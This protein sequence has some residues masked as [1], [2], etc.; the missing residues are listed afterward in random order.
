MLRI[1][2]LAI[3]SIISSLFLVTFAA[4]QLLYPDVPWAE[5]T[6]YP[7]LIVLAQVL[8]YLLVLIFIYFTIRQQSGMSF[9][10]SVRWNWPLNWGA[11]LFAGVVLSLG[12]Q[13]LAHFLP[14]PKNLPIDRFFQTTREAYVLSIF[15][16]T[17]APLLE[18]LFF[19]G[20]LY[21]VLARRLGVIAAVVLA[22]LS[23]GLIHAPQLG[24]AWG[25][26]LVISLVGLVLTITRA[27]TKSVAAGLLIH[28]AYNGTISVLIF[29]A[30]DRFRHLEKLQQ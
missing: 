16:V 7:G 1:A 20:L 5:V 29:F 25:P 26:V 18:E 19:R 24:R 28:T 4:R 3:A 21:P 14:M 2:C 22:S 15:G 17:L 8:A 10:Q 30:S 23:F 6:K 12:L 9:W 11:Y 27:V 13:G